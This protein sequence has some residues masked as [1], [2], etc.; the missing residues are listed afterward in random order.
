MLLLAA[1]WS[2][3]FLFIKLSIDEISP[4]TIAASRISLAALLLGV[5]LLLTTRPLPLSLTFWRHAAFMSIFSSALP[6]TL[7]CVAECSIESA[8]A[9]LLN[10]CSPLF[11]AVLAQL[12]IPSDRMHLKKLCGILLSFLGL[13]VLFSPNL[14]QGVQ[15][16]FL[17]MLAALSAA[18]CY[19][20][21]HVYGKK[22]LSTYPPFVVPTAQ[23][24]IS[25]LIL[26]PLAYFYETP[27]ALLTASG[28]A[29]TGV[30]GLG[31]MGTFFAFIVY[32]KLLK[33]SGP[34]AISAVACLF[35][36]ISMLLGFFFLQESLTIY[37]IIASFMIFT[38]LFLINDFISLPKKYETVS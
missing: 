30:L 13:V 7:F 9:G 19:A 36:I 28:T 25:S 21:S 35:P 33:E 4:L 38:G 27:S 8:L 37:G 20:I 10:G 3:S 12:F 34:T 16:S 24:T 31:L 23:L 29:L 5:L 1:L 22:F 18:L 6:F 17:G 26:W 15:G 2:P 14:L 11:T 32:Y